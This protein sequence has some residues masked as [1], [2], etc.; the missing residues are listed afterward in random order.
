LVP[1]P[2]PTEYFPDLRI[3]ADDWRRRRNKIVHGM[4]KSLPGA[5]H[6]DVLNFLKEAE[7]VAL[8]GCALDRAIANWGRKHKRRFRK[9]GPD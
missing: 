4:V 1:E 2:I 3:A 7:L 9:P 5:N 6:G 8:E